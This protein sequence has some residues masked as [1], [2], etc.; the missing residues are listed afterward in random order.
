M[1]ID[2]TSLPR[3][4][5]TF[6]VNYDEMGIEDDFSKWQE[7][8]GDDLE[9]FFL[10]GVEEGPRKVQFLFDEAEIDLTYPASYPSTSAGH[11]VCYL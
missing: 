11:F 7:S 2:F 6:F 10:I 3:L 5:L 9:T 8:G 1:I 4:R